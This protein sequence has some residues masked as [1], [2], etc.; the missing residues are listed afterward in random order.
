MGAVTTILIASAVVGAAGAT[1][2]AVQQR[3]AAKS[4]RRAQAAQQRQS[5]I[6]NARERAAAIRQA[7]IQRASVAAQA[8]NTGLTG[9]SSAAASMANIQSRTG[10]NLSFLDQMG[11]LSSA[12][13]H[14]NEAAASYMSRANLG[15]TIGNIA[16]SVGSIYGQAGGK[17]GTG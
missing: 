12:A 16:G 2:S 15:Q 9:S 1:Y 11:S 8:A 5:D 14:A 4:S 17:S 6:Q 13:S 3:K 10:E 7:R